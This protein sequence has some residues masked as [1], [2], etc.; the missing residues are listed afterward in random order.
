MKHIKAL[1][2]I[3][4]TYSYDGEWS[5]EKLKN[6]AIKHG[7]NALFIC[8]HNRNFSDK[9]FKSLIKECDNLSDDKVLLIPGIE[10][11]DADNIIHI[12]TFGLKN[13]ISEYSSINDLLQKVVKENGIAVYA[14][15]E[16]KH[17]Y[18]KID[19]NVFSLLNGIEVW[20]R[21]EDGIKPSKIAW[22]LYKKHKVTPFVSLDFHRKAQLFPLSILFRN[23]SLDKEEIL[24]SIRNG[25]LVSTAFGIP[26]SF[27][28][29]P[30]IYLCMVSVDYTRKGLLSIIRKIKR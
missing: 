25:K 30:I 14:H 29:N 23:I 26:I 27:F 20:N 2:H 17:S 5:L 12:C 9:K 28:Y 19:K 4:S 8:E 18:K 7:Y 6:S 15:P 13:L 1:F 16:G 24:E 21:K 11:E 22:S 10:Y 3:H